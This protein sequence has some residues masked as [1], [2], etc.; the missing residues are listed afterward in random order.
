MNSTGWA[1]RAS[2]G[3]VAAALAAAGL[4]RWARGQDGP[5]PPPPPPPAVDGSGDAAAA[6]PTTRPLSALAPG[7]RRVTVGFDGGHDTDGRD[8]GRPVVLIAAA[9]G[10]PAEVF[11][12]T[13]T[14]VHP[15]GPGRGPT[16]AEAQANKAALLA[17]LSPYGVTNDRLDAVSNYYRYLR[18]G[19]QL[20][21]HR[22]AVA[23]AVLGA[24]GKVV[25][26]DVV[27]AGAGYTTPPIVTVQ[28]QP[29]VRAVATVAFGTE[30]SANGSIAS[31]TT[32]TAPP[33]GE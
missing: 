31:L 21:R 8:R 30:L 10:V 23:Y 27:D 29:A 2:V 11:R 33:P 5:P 12:D 22:P 1:G 16:G 13:F 26:F 32:A 20:W 6:A 15:A 24:D 14:H 28:G 7:E 17:G 9:L 25:R 3:V 19:G 18:E 4:W